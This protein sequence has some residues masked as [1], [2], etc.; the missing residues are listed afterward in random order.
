MAD[1]LDDEAGALLAEAHARAGGRARAPASAVEA[2][3]QPV[4][5][6][7]P[8]D[9]TVTGN[10]RITAADAECGRAPHHPR[11]RRG[12]RFPVLEGQSIGIIPPG[13]DAAGK[14]HA[15][16][17]YSVAS[18]RDGER[19]NTNN[20]ALTVKRAEPP[21]GVFRVAPTISAI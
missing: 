19:P 16:R 15:M 13:T 14:P 4:Q 6:R 1:A 10:F 12:R 2:A 3:H 8:G 9:A 17:L 11:F 20:L 21:G 18:A 7:Q 5:P